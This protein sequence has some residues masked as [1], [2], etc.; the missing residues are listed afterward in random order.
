MSWALKDEERFASRERS[1]RI[2]KSVPGKANDMNR[3][4]E[5]GRWSEK[6]DS[7]LEMGI[8]QTHLNSACQAVSQSPP[9]TLGKSGHPSLLYPET[10]G[11]W[12]AGTM[13]YSS[14]QPPFLYTAW[15][16]V[17]IHVALFV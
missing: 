10:E 13:S 9:A 17:H 16:T 6:G 5:A 4:T 1:E 11:P 7:V 15:D 14:F 8:P 12:R 3:S 2:R